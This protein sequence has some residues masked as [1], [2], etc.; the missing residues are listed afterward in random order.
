MARFAGGL[1]IDDIGTERFP[2]QRLTGWLRWLPRESALWRS[3]HG[4]RAD[5]DLQSHLL[6]DIVDLLAAANWQR[7]GGKGTRPKPV[8]RAKARNVTGDASRL[9]QAQIRAVLDARRP[10]AGD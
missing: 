3:M 6:A 1:G 2:W 8:K 4:D 10:K 7:G 5:W 9:S